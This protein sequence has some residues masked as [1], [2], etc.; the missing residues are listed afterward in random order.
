MIAEK[1]REFGL[2]I[3]SSNVYVHQVVAKSTAESTGIKPDGVINK[4]DDQPIQNLH[5][6]LIKIVKN[7]QAERSLNYIRLLFVI[8]NRI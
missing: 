7:S 4:T 3:S 8:I 5:Q 6:D 1:A 2:S